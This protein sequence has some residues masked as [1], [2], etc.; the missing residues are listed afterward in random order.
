MTV[1]D[2][3]PV[4]IVQ[5]PMAG[6][7]STPELAAAVSQAGGLGFLAAGYQS[8]EGLRG[9]IRAVRRLTDRPFGVNLFVP[10]EQDA[11]AE[12]LARY[13]DRLEAEA[14]LYGA[15]L[16]EPVADDDGWADKLTVV[17]ESRVPV[18]SFTFGC[19]NAAAV[20]DL[21]RH[22]SEV[23]VTVTSA[24]EARQAADAGADALC[25]QGP[26]AGGHRGTFTNP[27]RLDDVSLLPLL[28]RVSATVDVPL[29]AA[30]GLSHGREVAAV[31]V[32]GARAAQLGTVFLRCPESGANPVHKAALT[33][34][35]F[36]G[37]TVTR[38]FS[39]RPARGLINRFVLDHS[40]G[41]PAAYPHVHHLTRGLRA[42]AV[43]VGDAEAM[44][45]WA[46]QGHPFAVERPAGELVET[47]G[48]QVRE[49]IAEVARR[50]ART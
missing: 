43:R 24:V 7:V 20:A 13:R 1:L 49:A 34:P 39:G 8:A 18:V 27:E 26:E 29:I 40:A 30:G 21:K 3:L 45:L 38:A 16:G 36:P 25:V 50:L 47:L 41:A 17:R 35:S 5:A 6:G 46:G 2:S 15:E 32:A 9:Q 12:A 31:L 19:P 37:T 42:A 22:A 10:G 28:R 48:A 44:S 14:A 33:D 11:D 23:V 4:P